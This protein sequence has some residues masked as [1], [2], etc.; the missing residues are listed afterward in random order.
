MARFQVSRADF[1]GSATLQPWPVAEPD[2][3]DKINRLKN[4]KC[5]QMMNERA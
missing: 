1:H 3:T 4:R 5:D 2:V